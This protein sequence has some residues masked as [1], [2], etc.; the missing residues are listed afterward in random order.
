[1]AAIGAR[2]SVRFSAATEL[3]T[4][5]QNETSASHR[6][7]CQ[8]EL[9]K[10]VGWFGVALLCG[11]CDVAGFFS[12]LKSKKDKCG[13]ADATE[14][15]KRKRKIQLPVITM[16]L[17][18]PLGSISLRGMSGLLFVPREPSNSRLRCLPHYIHIRYIGYI[19]GHKLQRNN[20][21]LNS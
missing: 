13:S 5:R 10:D 18:D 17:Q 12:R 14:Y 19:T 4:P 8:V 1:M 21:G 2:C 3:P 6:R 9:R 11:G 7:A 16:I 15:P 20:D